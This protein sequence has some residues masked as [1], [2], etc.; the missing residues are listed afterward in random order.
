M[1]LFNPP[2]NPYEFSHSGVKLT[3]NRELIVRQRLSKKRIDAIIDLHKTRIDVEEAVKLTPHLAKEYF[4]QWTT[5]Q[6]QLQEVWGVHR[7][8]NLS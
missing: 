1:N 4:K 6:Y 8:R 3:L 5:I 7:R 2:E